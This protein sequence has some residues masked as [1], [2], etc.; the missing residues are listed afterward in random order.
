[1]GQYRGLRGNGFIVLDA[2]SYDLVEYPEIEEAQGDA[3]RRANQTGCAIV[4]AP[5]AVI[6]PKI[7]DVTMD[8]PKVMKSLMGKLGLN[9]ALASGNAP[10]A[11][12]NGVNAGPFPSAEEG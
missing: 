2:G 3:A 12:P 11:A 8:V 5:V 9:V 7:D 10:D 4:Y 1:M 6:R